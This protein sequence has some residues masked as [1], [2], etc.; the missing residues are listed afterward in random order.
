MTALLRILIPSRVRI[1]EA[2]ERHALGLVERPVLRGFDRNTW[3]RN[4]AVLCEAGYLRPYVHG[5]FEI[6]DI[7]RTALSQIS[8]SQAS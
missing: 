4:A 2:A 7:G 8:S 5:G 6:T 1:L 3:D